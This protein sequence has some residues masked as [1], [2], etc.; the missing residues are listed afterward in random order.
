M[1]P[2]RFQDIIIRVRPLGWGHSQD[3]HHD[4]H[5]LGGRLQELLFLQSTECI[6]RALKLRIF[7][8]LPVLVFK[9]T[10]KFGVAMNLH[11]YPRARVCLLAGTVALA[12][13]RSTPS[14]RPR[15]PVKP[16]LRGRNSI[17]SRPSS[18]TRGAVRTQC[19]DFNASR[20][21]CRS[22]RTQCRGFDAFGVLHSSAH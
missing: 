13:H 16:K 12:S 10:T 3:Q 4:H 5:P 7:R 15:V 9:S 11:T 14:G 17:I 2:W 20:S 8:R 1:S 22:V 6:L 21:P 19:H 18:S